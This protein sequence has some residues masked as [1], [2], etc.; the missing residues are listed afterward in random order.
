[1]S[2]LILMYISLWAV[3]V[4]ITGY[5]PIPAAFA[6]VESTSICFVDELSAANNGN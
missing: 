1:M 3:A 4:N 6:A 5:K 2:A